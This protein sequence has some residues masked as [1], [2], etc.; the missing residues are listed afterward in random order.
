MKDL[1]DLL[2]KLPNP[3]PKVKAERATESNP[4]GG[5]VPPPSMDKLVERA[6]EGKK[7]FKLKEKNK[8]YNY[9]VAEYFGVSRSHV[10]KRIVLFKDWEKK[11]GQFK[12]TKG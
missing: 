2:P 1:V 11:R 4:R 9:Q 6:M 10:D 12:V 7:F 5:G 3:K 8:W